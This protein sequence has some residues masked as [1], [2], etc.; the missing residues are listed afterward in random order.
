M[1]KLF[2][3]TY[4]KRKSVNKNLDEISKKL[5]KNIVIAYSIQFQNIAKEIKKILSKN[6][7]ITKFFQVLGCSK[8]L[9]PKNTQ[10]ILL[11]GS[12]K[13][14]A[15][16]LA[17]ETKKPIFFLEQDTLSQISPKNIDELKKKQKASY[18][19]YLNANKIGIIVSTK[20]GQQRLKQAL[21]FKNSLKD[22]KSY[23][24][25]CNNISSFEL[26]NFPEIKSWINTACLRLDL[27]N[28]V[29]NLKDLS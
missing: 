8:P 24:F 21:Q 14:H 12:G 3:P 25:L 15:T 7:K 4:S 2:M 17:L 16:S 18:L 29:I 22:K 6:H 5:P 23:L 1:K 11:I 27:N 13:F 28:E 9:I 19:K 20:P 10:A 26:E